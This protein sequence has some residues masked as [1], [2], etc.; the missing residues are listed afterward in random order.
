MS[1]INGINQGFKVYSR[2]WHHQLRIE[3]ESV[4]F[5]ILQAALQRLPS[6]QR[7]RIGNFPELAEDDEGYH[8]LCD[9]LFGNKLEP[10]KP[11]L[12]GL[13]HTRHL[14]HCEIEDAHCERHQIKRLLLEEKRQN[15]KTSSL[16]EAN[17]F[18]LLLPRHLQY[19]IAI[20]LLA[21]QALQSLIQFCSTI[22][23]IRAT[24]L[25]LNQTTLIL[26]IVRLDDELR[27][28]RRQTLTKYT[29]LFSARDRLYVDGFAKHLTQ[30]CCYIAIAI[31]MR[32]FCV[33][34]SCGIATRRMQQ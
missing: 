1:Y 26:S 20:R 29:A 23:N 3:N 18:Y 28:A 4:P 25:D 27:Q 19:Q 7:I 12:I 21:K 17:L 30:C 8:E 33:D 6:L 14:K 34:D 22:P 24:R 16:L 13:F 31:P 11:G 5:H 9:R 32:T 10:H 2:K 15:I